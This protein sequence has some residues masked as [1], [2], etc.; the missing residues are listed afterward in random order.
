MEHLNEAIAVLTIITMACSL[1]FIKPAYQ[2]W[3][4]SRQDRLMAL[5]NKANE[6]LIKTYKLQHQAVEDELQAIKKSQIADLHD[7]INREGNKLIGQGAITIDQLNNFDYLYNAYR[8][9]GG[10]GTGEVIANQVHNLPIKDTAGKSFVE[11]AEEL[12]KQREAEND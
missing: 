9:L 5:I 7:K 12:H 3:R 10:N 1:P 6:S 4:D 11:T 8:N 2:L